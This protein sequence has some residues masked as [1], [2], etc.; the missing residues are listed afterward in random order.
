[1]RRLYES[2]GYGGGSP[3]LAWARRQ[4]AELEARLL[5]RGFK[6]LA[7]PAMRYWHPLPD[8][9]VEDLKR[10]GAEQFLVLPAYPQYSGATSGSVL[11]AICKA[12]SSIAPG[13][14]VHVIA[15]WYLLPGYL[16]ALA[17]RVLPVLRRWMS[18]GAPARECALLAVAHSLPE[19]FI[20]RGDPYLNQTRATVEGFRK[21]AT[22][23]LSDRERAWW[24][25]LPGGGQPLLAFQSKVGPVKWVGPAVQDETLRLAENGC[26]RLLVFP[27]S[28]TCEHIETLYE[29][30]VELAGTAAEAGVT[31][32]VRTEALNL[33]PVWLG[34]LAGLLAVNAFGDRV[35]GEEGVLLEARRG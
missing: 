16:D 24:D 20:K 13:A 21:L 27:V 10:R 7:A 8:E 28:F 34:S 1:M 31:D 25:D 15:D 4:C 35:A 19:R 30:D 22:E 17:G 29:L 26:R 11:S 3:Q 2:L 12:I 32:Y 5:G 9:T 33:N 6:V 23:H 18:E 14:R